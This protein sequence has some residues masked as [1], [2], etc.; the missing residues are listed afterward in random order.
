MYDYYQDENACLYGLH[1][2]SEPLHVMLDPVE[3]MVMIV[4]NTLTWHRDMKLEV[5][6]YDMAGKERR[7]TQVYEE[8]GPS[9][10]RKYLPFGRGIDRMRKDKGIFLSLRLLD[11]H[12]HLISDNFY[13]L[14]DSTGQFSGLQQI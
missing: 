12:K 11:E 10:V 8:I 7:L 14:P 9:T 5:K 6:A 4:I 1:N 2:G 3:N 13:W